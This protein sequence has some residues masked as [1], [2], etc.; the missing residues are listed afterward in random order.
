MFCGVRNVTISIEWQGMDYFSP[1]DVKH[2]Q[3]LDY[4]LS[5]QQAI[6]IMKPIVA[7]YSPE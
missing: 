6:G 5:K 3:G 4:R 2:G 7:S 1:S